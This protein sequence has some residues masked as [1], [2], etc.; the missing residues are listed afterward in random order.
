[1]R[2]TR[3]ILRRSA[4]IVNEA[5][6]PQLTSMVDMMTILL[7]FLLKSFSVEG[8]LATA[9]P[10]LEL[11]ESTSK[12]RAVPMLNLVLSQDG[13]S[14]D[15]VEVVD[16]EEF[17]SSDSLL[18]PRLHETL[19]GIANATGM[20]DQDNEVLIQCDRRLDFRV[21][22]KVMFTCAQAGYSDFSLLV[23]REG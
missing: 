17:V 20:E 18:V 3:S 21:V 19:R 6:R 7:V 1:M 15:G 2:P 13:V 9:A 8:N 11:A 4:E 16:L 14:V 12:D 10:N 22:K 23:A 5:P